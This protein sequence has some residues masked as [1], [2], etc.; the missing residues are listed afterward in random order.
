MLNGVKSKIKVRQYSIIQIIRTPTIYFGGVNKE[1]G[2][3]M[4]IIVLQCYNIV[5]MGLKILLGWGGGGVRI[6][7]GDFQVNRVLF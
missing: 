5:K 4:D 1:R 2:Q 3:C 6:Y 7:D